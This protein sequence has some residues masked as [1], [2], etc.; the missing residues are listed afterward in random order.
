MNF[1]L[2]P[3]GINRNLK[4]QSLKIEGYLFCVEDINTNERDEYLETSTDV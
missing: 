2:K 4:L 3:S 1:T